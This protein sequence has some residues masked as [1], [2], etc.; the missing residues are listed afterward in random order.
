MQTLDKSTLSY[1]IQ[2]NIHFGYEENMLS[3]DDMV[4]I[5]ELMFDLLGLQTY[6]E[7]SKTLSMT[8]N[9]ILKTN[10]VKRININQHKYVINNL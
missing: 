4:Q 9:G 8:Y 5:I 3:D 6:S 1:K 10:T 2:K 7:A